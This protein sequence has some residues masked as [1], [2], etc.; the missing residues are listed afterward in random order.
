[1]KK[2]HKKTAIA[3]AASWC[4]II[5]F[6]LFFSCEIGLG[7]A[8]DVQPPSITIESPKVDS[9]IRDVFALSGRW[10]DDGIIDGVRVVLKRTDADGTGVGVE[11][12]GEYI[13]DELLKSTGTWKAIV[14]Y[15]EAKLSDGTYQA[16]VYIKDKGKHETTQSTT[17]TIDNTAPVLVLSRPSTKFGALS[18]DSYGQTFTLEGKAADE[19]EVSLIEVNIYENED[20]TEPL[21]TVAIKSVPLTIEQD[22]AKYEAGKANDYALIYGHT[23][24]DGVIIPEQIHDS[25]QRYC[26]ISIYDGAQ[27]FPVDGSA[28]TEEDKKGNFTN[29]YYMNSEMANI[30]ADFKINELYKIKNGNYSSDDEEKM[31]LA[32]AVQNELAEKEITKGQFKINPANNPKFVVTSRSDLKESEDLDNLNYQLT[33]G[34][35]YLEVE[36]A[37]GLDNWPIDTDSVG[38]YLQE[39]DKNGNPRYK[40]EK[41]ADIAPIWLI[42]TGAENHTE[43]KATIVQTG[44]T[45]K[46]KT[47]KQIAKNNYPG[48]KIGSYYLICVEGKDTR[49]VQDGSEIISDGIFAFK[50]VS[51][52]ELIELSGSG[53][54]EYI[55]SNE[56]AWSVKGH[57]K[58]TITLKWN[59]PDDEFDVYR[60]FDNATEGEIIASLKRKEGQNDTSWVYEDVINYSFLKSKNFPEGIN[61]CIKKNGDIVSTTIFIRLR[62]DDVVPGISNIQFTNSYVKVEQISEDVEKYTYYVK[63]DGTNN[64]DI[65]GIA[66]DDTNIE[67]VELKIPGFAEGAIPKQKNGRFNFKAVDFSSL[68]SVKNL[69]ANIIATDV[70]GNQTT[71]PI[72]IIFDTTPPHGVHLIDASSKNLYF[73]IGQNDNDDITPANGEGNHGVVWNDAKDKNVGGKYGNGTF[74]NATTIQIRGNFTDQEE[75]GAQGSGVRII[76]YKVYAE[77]HLL[78]ENTEQNPDAAENYKK[79]LINDVRE[80]YTGRISLLSEPEVKRVFYNVAQKN[81][82]PDSSQIFGGTQLTTTPNGKGYYKYYKEIE[83]NFN[84]TLSG[85]NEGNNYLVLVVEDNVGNLAIDS[86]MVVFEDKLSEFVNYTLNVDKTPPSDI[87]KE[88]VSGVLY[89]NAKNALKL[90]GTVS[91]KTTKVDGEGKMIAAG[92]DSFVLS[93]DGVS[94]TI[95]ATLTGI[96]TAEDSTLTKWEADV[97]SL[98]PA[99]GTVSISATAKDKAGTGNTTPGVVATIT[100]D[101]TAPTVTIDADSPSDADSLTAGIQVNGTISLSGTADD[102]NGIQELIGLYYKTYTGNTEPS[103]PAADTVIAATG[104]DGWKPVSATK[105]GTVN[106]KFTDIDTTKLDG[107]N[108]IADGTKVCFTVAVKDRAG[109]IG[110]STP[111]AVVVNQDTDRPVIHLT[112]LPLTGMTNSSYVWFNRSELTGTIDDDDG[113]VEYVKV[114]AKDVTEGVPT[115][116]EWNSAPNAYK[117]GIWSYTI[118]SN[119]SKKIFFQIKD[120]NNTFTSNVASTTAGSY[121]PKILDPNSLKFGY[122]GEGNIADDIVYVKVDTDDPVLENLYYYASDENIV[123]DQNNENILAL[124]WTLAESSNIP[125]KFGGTKK[126]L[127]FK[128]KTFDTNGIAE[129]TPKFADKAPVEGKTKE[130]PQPAGNENYKEFITC[131]DISDVASTRQKLEINIKD[132]AAANTNSVGIVKYYE[133]EIDN[134]PPEI[135]FSNYSK[136]AQVYGSSAV[137][138]RGTTSDTNK[139]VKVEYALSDVSNGVPLDGSRW[140]EITDTTQKT[141]TSTL[142]WQMIFDGKKEADPNFEDHY[143]YHADYLKNTLFD[144]YQVTPENQPTYDTTEKIYIW[145]RA[146]DELGNFC[147]N[148][149][150]SSGE[151]FYLD[152]IPNGDRPAVEITYPTSGSSVGGTIRITGTTEIQ[153]TSANVKYVYIQIDPSY[154]GSFSDSWAS[155]LQTLMGNDV[156]AYE[157]KD[158]TGVVVEGTT[159]NLGEKIGH[160]IPSKGNSNTNW[161]L[162]INSNKE[163]NEKVGGKNREIG[164]RAAAVSSTGK[165]SFSEVYTCT[166]DPDAPIFGQTRELRFVQFDEQRNEIASRKYENGL[167]LKGQ[168]YLVGSVQDESGIRRIAVDGQDIVKSTGNTGEEVVQNISNGMAIENEI[169]SNIARFCNY[170]LK[171][172]VGDSTPDKFGKIDYEISVTDGSVG[173]IEN[174]LKFTVYYDNKAPDFQAQKGNGNDLTAGGKIYQSNGQYTVM[175]SY[176]EP[177]EG[178]NNQSGFNRIAMFFTRKRKV[179]ENTT[180]LF[181]LDPMNEDGSNGQENFVQLGTIDNSGNIS[182]ESGISKKDGLYWRAVKAT[183]AN[184]REL[185]V[186]NESLVNG[187]IPS[188]IRAGGI[189]MVDNVSYRIKSISGAKVNLEGNLT[190]FTTAKTVY[191]AFAQIIDNLSQESG[192][193]EVYKKNVDDK[194]QID[195]GDGDWMAEGVQFSG[196]SYIWNASLDSSNMLDGIIDMCFVAYDAAGNFAEESWTQKISN[197]E[198]RI[199]GVIFGTDTNLDGYIKAEDNEIITSYKNDYQNILNHK[200]GLY[201]NGQNANGERITSF[202]IAEPLTVKGALFVKPLIVGGNTNLGWQ[203]SYTYK[204]G[205]SKSTEVLSYFDDEN[206]HHSSDGSVRA[207]DLTID[208]SLEDFVRKEIKEGNQNLTFTIWDATDGSTIGDAA[209]GSARADVI[210]PVNIIISDSAYPTATVEPFKWKNASENSLYKNSPANGHIELETDWANSGNLDEDD[211]ELDA[212]PK[213]SGKITFDVE[214]SDNVIV[215]KL[216]VKIDGY[217]GGEGEGHAFVIAERSSSATTTAGWSSTNMYYENNGEAVEGA[218]SSLLGANAKDWVFELLSD[219]YAG[220]GTNT[221]KF[222]FHFDTEKITG[223]ADTDVVVLFSAEDK[224]SPEWDED[225]GKIVYGNEKASDDPSQDASA[226]TY[227]IDVVPYITMVST[228]LAN[229]KSNNPSVYSRTAKGNYAVADTEVLNFEGFNISGGQVK[230]ATKTATV[231]ASYDPDAG[232]EGVGGYAIPS[233]AKSGSIS[234]VVSNIESLNNLNNN[235]A[236][237][238]YQGTTTSVTGD[239]AIY[240]NYYNRQ[241][242]GDNNNL[243]TDD[244]VL[245]IWLFKDA[246]IS[247][248]SGYITEPIMKINPK[249]GML[250]FGF[251]SGPANYC[252]GDGQTY[253]YKTW[254]A[255]Y[256]RFSTCGFTVDENGITHGITVGLDTNPGSSGSAGRLQYFT[257]KWGRSQLDTNGNYEGGNSS[258]IDNIGAPPGTYNGVTFDGYAFI[259]DRFASPSLVTAIHDSDTYVFLAYY[260]DLNGQIRFK[261]GNLSKTTVGTS[262][263]ITANPSGKKGISF[264]Q[265]ADQRRYKLVDGSNINDNTHTAFD[266][267]SKPEYYSVIA[268]PSMTAKAGNYVS[269]DILKGDSIASDVIVATWYDATTNKWYYSYKVN[270]CTDN[271]LGAG[272]GSG[273]WATPIMLKANAGENCQ[274]AVDKVGGIHIASYD[275]ENADLLYAYLSSYDDASPQVV[276]VD[277]YAFTGTNIRLDT[278][279]SDDGNYIVPYI[280]YY[281]SSTQKPKMAYLPGVVSSSTT[282]ATREAVTI[283]AGVDQTEA[284]T[285]MWEQGLVPTAS[286]Y[287]DNYAY[288]YV[289]IGLY[290]DTTTGKAKD[291][292]GT[293]VTY[294]DLSGLGQENTSKTYGNGTANPVMAYATRVGTRGHL[295]TAQMK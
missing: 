95:K 270:P 35:S 203:Y 133:A 232:G 7:S 145:M 228:S 46:F 161:Y 98:L 267:N 200:D 240:D 290:K 225:L 121:G 61:Y 22:V 195:N 45:Y 144:L 139:V 37:P 108:A 222:K 173:E 149:I 123:Y 231:N 273:Y 207:D 172:P 177:S 163:F 178:D 23:D 69:T 66:T 63:N 215:Q 158:L 130:L 224:G 89:T 266:S 190:D 12:Q 81:G 100:V 160:G 87:T 293:D 30:L 83:S 152:V 80:N 9:V 171:I 127:Y 38:V 226:G 192:K 107:T 134:T 140:N 65:S 128:Y 287:A 254:V 214:A 111:K 257:S 17:F 193:T 150:D 241:P 56:A 283:K 275:G 151:G 106:W 279:V 263:T 55:S 129:V 120:K 60:I 220:D 18:F 159:T 116:S 40:D 2:L 249:N 24:A 170:D 276:T 146:T 78:P 15:K 50:L 230:F 4:L 210:L 189:C 164:I 86:A 28:Q 167:Y 122:T 281:M 252:M 39:C 104:T 72:E 245:D 182:Y 84:E 248:T 71:Y 165:V 233:E 187:E 97:S 239:K 280:G 209:S 185:T 101:K 242:N 268:G 62:Y 175:G 198:P 288:S 218:A 259:E 118:T 135:S 265:F 88:G 92:I 41:G 176:S 75:N 11:I 201:Y 202:E 49:K 236:K 205:T 269:I 112:S 256:A 217:D 117:N 154:N 1:M 125:D 169:P 156:T 54:P 105:N 68:S 221:V 96:P 52:G 247:Q 238:S 36:I 295:E 191:F 43:D 74:G 278:V 166:I 153:D 44:E 229:L 284:L 188:N 76:Y 110:Y 16:T 184:G 142:A 132:N 27:R 211:A 99:S 67:S 82:A 258:R 119:G 8:V 272:T 57:E 21:K 264:E 109:N 90:S 5:I 208:I 114:I 260:D 20:S 250:N 286:R 285:G 94:T 212:D 53:E 219:E 77:E 64:S 274:I 253:S 137:T 19:N 155:E 141:Y 292:T 34:N 223:T 85:F 143:S 277:A 246:G 196:G 14:D 42:Q 237:G 186:A 181:L 294:T 183:L 26:T 13:E 168:W 251:N 262:N 25:E 243:L 10:S 157:I 244:V 113:A 147:T 70:A 136:G 79:A 197:N 234:F 255:N 126:Y 131:F 103:A 29:A 58:L 6:S 180:N 204:D 3:I 199:A 48:L 93:R 73:R 47:A 31:T 162:A 33:A 102:E 291:M 213:V 51:T 174:V 179:N 194:T 282:K 227:Q 216:F 115:E 271:D 148:T 124:N 289:N 235:N 261:Y 32:A 59:N 138:L 206:N 91:D